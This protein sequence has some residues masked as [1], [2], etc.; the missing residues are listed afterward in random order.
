MK[1]LKNAEQKNVILDND[2]YS[3]E[4]LRDMLNT[5][6]IWYFDSDLRVSHD[7]SLIYWNEYHEKEFRVFLEDVEELKVVYNK[8][9]GFYETIAV[10]KNGAKLHVKL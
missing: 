2:L 5:E 7:A 10:L 8:E 1:V 4:Q 3:W 9:W 6:I